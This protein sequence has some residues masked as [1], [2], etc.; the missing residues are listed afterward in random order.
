MTAPDGSVTLYR[1]EMRGATVLRRS[2]WTPEM[3]VVGE[4][5]TV[6][7]APDRIDPHA[8]YVNTLVLADGRTLDRYTQRAVLGT[9][10]PPTGVQT[11]S[12]RLRRPARGC[13]N[14]ERSAEPGRRLGSRAAADDGSARSAG[15]A[16]SGQHRTAVRAGSRAGARRRD[17]GVRGLGAA[18]NALLQLPRRLGHRGKTGRH[19]RDSGVVSSLVGAQRDHRGQCCR[20]P[21]R[22]HG[23]DECGER[24]RA[25]GHAQ[26]HRIP[27]QHTV[28]LCGHQVSCHHSEGR[29]EH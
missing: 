12:A 26:R 16:G 25:S 2:G 20:C 9:T 14:L 6:Q 21:R 18:R 17:T 13:E 3:F 28:Q 19:R 8:C 29:P 10:G 7:G 4:R 27:E 24:Q 1:C 5:I 11:T 23:G 22:H 15:H